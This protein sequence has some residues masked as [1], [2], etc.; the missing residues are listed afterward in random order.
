[1][2][3]NIQ[4]K[5]YFVKSN[6]GEIPAILEW[7]MEQGEGLLIIRD[8]SHY[9]SRHYVLRNLNKMETVATTY[10]EE[11]STVNNGKLGFT[12]AFVGKT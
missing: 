7:F 8:P 5:S 11:V 4:E 2:A 12:P 6:I 10:Q 3:D 1:M 9:A